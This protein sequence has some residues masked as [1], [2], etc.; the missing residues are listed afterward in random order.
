MNPKRVLNKSKRIIRRLG[1]IVRSI[2]EYGEVFAGS[3][4][5]DL[6]AHTSEYK[7]RLNEGASLDDILP[8]A[9]ATV[10]EAARRTVGLYPY[11]VQVIAGILLYRGNIVEQ[12]TGEGKTL[13]AAFPAYLM[14]LAGK[15]VHVVT[16]NDYLASRDAADIGRIYSFLG[17]STG[18]VVPGMEQCDRRA[19][20]ACDITYVTN[21]EAGF[22][23]LRDN[24]VIDPADRVQRGLSCA[25]IDEVDSILIDEARTPLI[26]SSE[27]GES[28]STYKM[29]QFVV[30]QLT[31]GEAAGE[32][33]KRDALEG[34]LVE[35]TG[36]YVVDEKDKSAHLTSEGIAKVERL[37]NIND[38]SDAKYSNLRHQI[39][40]ALRANGAFHKERDYIVKDGE[41]I[42]VDEF[43]GRLMHGR[44]YSDGLHQA[45]EAKEGVDIKP[46]SRIHA[47]ITF[48]HF[49][50]KYAVK[51]GM[52][53][54]A[55][56]A[57]DEFKSIY[58]MDTVCVPTNE[59]MIRQDLDDA[60][61]LTR[62]AKTAAIVKEIIDANKTGRPVLVGTPTIDE[63]EFLS[64]ALRRL[65][66]PHVVLN[67]KYH[68]EEAEIIARAGEEGRV[69][70][71]TNM[72]GRGT[73]IKLSD[74]SREKGGLY[75]I[76]TARH[77]ARRIDDQLR[78]RSGRQGDPGTSK[79]FLSLE[80][81]VTRLFG[82]QKLISLLR[83]SGVDE[84]MPL[85]QRSVRKLVSD[86]QK[87]IESLNFS[88]RKSLLDFD[89][90]NNEHREFVYALRNRL[91]D[92][93]FDPNDMMRHM[94]ED[95]AA[96][97]V[98]KYCV[99]RDS[100][101][102]NVGDMQ[103]EFYRTF[104]ADVD[105]VNDRKDLISNAVE[106]VNIEYDKLTMRFSS[107]SELSF[108]KRFVLLRSLDTQ[109]IEHIN[110][111]DRL[112]ES[113]HFVGYGQKDP[114]VVYKDK[115]YADLKKR[116]DKAVTLAVELVFRAYPKVSEVKV[117][118]C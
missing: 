89:A 21:N 39:Q 68:A 81:D 87:K 72:A 86:A 11:D 45:I 75:V 13:T 14:A 83:M 104:G 35:E 2:K 50:N 5:E 20:Y 24:M 77:E 58:G 55:V 65:N 76:G 112:R 59:P 9:F 100:R 31:K 47:T 90:V 17:L 22:D 117:D 37:L 93:S 3:S 34:R 28:V 101:N 69:T 49:F 19:A 88:V 96:V 62:A 85:E 8:E 42:I 41:V 32:L 66:V 48:Q 36:D 73:D 46:E 64:M 70:I 56:T 116:L 54:T 118:A 79:F 113:V 57:A 80:D 115:A 44:R 40:M 60:V 63:S 78:G 18:C 97:I 15:G 33:T 26:I 16:V 30:S 27:S 23:Y 95:R 74:E 105:V 29:C 10:R 94:I 38:Y 71:A 84:N 107:Y 106:A 82:S 61:Y 12:A 114:V 7:R 99:G 102:W 1:P 6:K 91:L 53:G 111:L 110:D 4:D 43:T 108:M 98:D 52:T 103:E 25:I 109:W 92:D 67:A 51:A